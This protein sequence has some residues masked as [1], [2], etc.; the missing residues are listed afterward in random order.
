MSKLKAE[1]ERG[2]RVI[3]SNVTGTPIVE[4]I[5]KPSFEHALYKVRW[6]GSGVTRWV[7]EH[8][9]ERKARDSEHNRI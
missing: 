8:E 9:I 2:D 1:Y 5:W 6:T 3:V 4:S 7:Y